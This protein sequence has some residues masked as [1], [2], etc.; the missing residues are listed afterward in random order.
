MQVLLRRPLGMV[1]SPSTRVIS[2]W[3]D[4]GQSK[5]GP[6]LMQIGIKFEG[7]YLLLKLYLLAPCLLDSIG[8]SSSGCVEDDKQA[9]PDTRGSGASGVV[10]VTAFDRHGQPFAKFKVPR[11]R[12]AQLL[13][14]IKRPSGPGKRVHTKASPQ[15][16]QRRQ[17]G[18]QQHQGEQQ[19]QQQRFQVPLA[20]M[21]KRALRVYTAARAEATH[22]RYVSPPRSMQQQ[23]APRSV[24]AT[25]EELYPHLKPPT[26][27]MV[28][29]ATASVP[30][31]PEGHERSN[32]SLHLQR[33]PEPP[34]PL[35][36]WSETPPWQG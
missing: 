29:D 26:E 23:L 15:L 19:G 20:A 2:S 31:G 24:H 18:Q 34:L 25:A 6:Q 22:I 4:E 35:L 13:R 3:R 1:S 17:Q 33:S 11:L 14:A 12:S 16:Q 7:K 8:T 10:L 28:Y 36:N 21:L 32:T 27:A 9:H 30:R 5:I